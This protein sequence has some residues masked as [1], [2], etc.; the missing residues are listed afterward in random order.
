MKRLK[1]YIKLELAL[2]GVF[3]LCVL[4]FQL[5][6]RN[7]FDT[8]EQKMIEYRGTLDTKEFEVAEF[9][10]LYCESNLQVQYKLGDPKVVITSAEE[11]INKI[12]IKEQN[13][14]LE[15]REKSDGFRMDKELQD[16]SQII[17]YGPILSEIRTDRNTSVKVTDRLELDKMQ[18]ESNGNS[19]IVV[20]LKAKEVYSSTNGNSQTTVIGEVDELEVDSYGNSSHYSQGCKSEDVK[21]RSNGNSSIRVKPTVKIEG[22]AGG[23]STLHI[24]GNPEVSNTSS[25]GNASIRNY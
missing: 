23:N 2:L 11:I 17:V 1:N 9:G 18:L 13:G 24:H 14:W 8:Y 25:S 21:A 12:E 19:T 16:A 10:K 3:F 4:I 20:T 15:I 5:F 6:V 7:E 22:H